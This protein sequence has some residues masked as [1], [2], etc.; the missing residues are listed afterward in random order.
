MKSIPDFQTAEQRAQWVVANANYFTVVRRVNRSY[1]RYE[2]SSLD[3][4]SKLAQRLANR[5][6]TR[7]MIYAV[8]GPY[9]TYVT[10]IGADK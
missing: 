8:C 9:D 5:L 4:A 6:S 2:E 1:E 10:T 7:Y 3:S